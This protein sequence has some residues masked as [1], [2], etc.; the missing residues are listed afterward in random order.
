MNSLRIVIVCVY[1]MASV[2]FGLLAAGEV[3]GSGHI[4]SGAPVFVG[5]AVFCATVAVTEFRPWFAKALEPH[6]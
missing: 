4:M 1:A 6:Q 2:C 3:L 5:G